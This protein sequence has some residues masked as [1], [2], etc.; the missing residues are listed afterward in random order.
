MYEEWTGAD[1]TALRKT[2]GLTVRRF[3]DHAVVSEG[4]VKKWSAALGAVTLNEQSVAAL[5]SMLAGL[6]PTQR[7]R[8]EKLRAAYAVAA[9]ARALEPVSAAA[10]DT[11]WAADTTAIAHD[12][13]RKDMLLDRRQASQALV[14][15]VVGVGL[16]E[17]L[18]RWLL[19]RPPAGGSMTARRYPEIDELE[20]TA[21]MFRAWDD[22]FGG[23]LRRKAVVGQLDE[24]NELVRDESDP[25]VRRRLQRVMSLLSET[26]ATMAWDSGDQ[27]AAQ[28]YYVLAVK[29]GR[30]SEDPALCANA[31]AGMARQMLTLD[32]TGSAADRTAF[33]HARAA[34]ALELVRVAQDHFADRVTA[35]M[36]ALMFTRE[37]WAYARLG[38]PSAFERAADKA[39]SAFATADVAEDPY[40][41][42]YFDAAELSGTLGGRLLELAREEPAYAGQAAEAIDEAITLR[43]PERWRSS[44]LDQLGTAE[45]R[46]IQGEYEEA[47][48]LGLRAL[49]TAGQTRSHRVQRKVSHIFARTE[50][51]GD[52]QPVVELRDMLRPLAPSPA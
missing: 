3:A 9:A 44:A 42:H 38:R 19:R 15:L 23:G 33:R 1:A 27:Q 16:L 51:C 29:S 25:G 4:A 37:A 10:A 24:V 21:Q 31:I 12:L 34:D 11:I 14:G 22:R 32:T 6:S 26:A 18:E 50:Q 20:H 8:F 39:R 46:L 30:E 17:P 28:G 43:Q 41:I 7:V 13:A 52:A 47:N 40:W 2:L 36:R 45:A 48:R 49:E 5:E 35:T